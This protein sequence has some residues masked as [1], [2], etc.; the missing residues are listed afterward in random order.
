MGSAIANLPATE[1]QHPTE[2]SVA[3]VG[4][5]GSP[6]CW[7][8]PQVPIQIGGRFHRFQRITTDWIVIVP[9]INACDATYVTL[10]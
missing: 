4:V 5:V 3:I 6:C 10:L 2:V 7:A 1:I 9:A 8:Q